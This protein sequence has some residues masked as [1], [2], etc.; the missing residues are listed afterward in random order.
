[1][2]LTITAIIVSLLT[3]GGFFGFKLYQRAEMKQDA[4]AYLL[5]SIQRQSAR[6][7]PE[8]G[9]AVVDLARPHIDEIFAANYIS[10][11]LTK[12]AEFD[13]I[14][15]TRGMYE[16][17]HQQLPSMELDEDVANLITRLYV[18]SRPIRQG[19]LGGVGGGMLP[20]D[21][22]GADDQDPES[23]DEDPGS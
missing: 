9:A 5:N 22:D 20:P 13:D 1:M 11:G 7:T 23:P 2:R 12:P 6:F 10:G 15:F 16:K 4:E 17:L 18:Q 8:A 19:M 21:E 14:G 3:V